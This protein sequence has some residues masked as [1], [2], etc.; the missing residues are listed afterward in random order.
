M[1]LQPLVK[2]ALKSAKYG[3][4]NCYF[5]SPGDTSKEVVLGVTRLH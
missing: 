2:N 5:S 4:A 1:T 3:R